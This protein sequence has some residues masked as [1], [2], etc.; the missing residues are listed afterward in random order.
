MRPQ[1]PQ[2]PPGHDTLSERQEKLQVRPQLLCEETHAAV[3]EWPFDFEGH[4]LDRE[5]AGL[6]CLV[7]GKGAS[8]ILGRP[9]WSYFREFRCTPKRRRGRPRRVAFDETVYLEATGATQV[10]PGRARARAR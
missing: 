6:R 3:L 1:A 10:R 9:R 8:D 2:V 5:A 4:T 7:C